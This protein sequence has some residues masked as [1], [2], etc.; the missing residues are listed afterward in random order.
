[1][2]EEAAGG[3]VDTRQAAVDGVTAV[4]TV[5]A[6]AKGLGLLKLRTATFQ[7]VNKVHGQDM[8]QAVVDSIFEVPAE[9]A[10]VLDDV[11]YAVSGANVVP[12]A[13]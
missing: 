10:S 12:A 13:G 5:P 2:E 8:A 7:V 4:L 9:L 3:D 6:N 11:G 1:M